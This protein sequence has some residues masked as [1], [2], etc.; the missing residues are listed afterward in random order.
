MDTCGFTTPLDPLFVMLL[1]FSS[2]PAAALSDQNRGKEKH[3]YGLLLGTDVRK[4]CTL[5]LASPDMPSSV[6]RK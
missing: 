4:D 1:S 5:E 3:Q 2:W 6:R